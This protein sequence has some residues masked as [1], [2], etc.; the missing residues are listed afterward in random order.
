M[1]GS[2][3]ASASPDAN[4]P[5]TEESLLRGVQ[6]L[7]DRDQDLAQISARL[8]PPPLWPREPGFAT[9]I[10]IILEQQVSLASARAAFQ[11]LLA[12]ANPLT[13][14]TFL[15]LDDDALK[16]AGFSRQKTRYGRL[17]AQ[18]VLD[19]ALDI[20]GLAELDDAA[21]HAQLTAIKGIGPWTANIY[22]L[23]ALRRPD[24]WPSADL[25]LMVAVQR[26][27]GLAARP[28]VQEMEAL[29]Q[30]WRPWRAVAARLLWH[31]YLN[32]DA[33]I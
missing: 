2:P 29:G 30:V 7:I 13:P 20:D 4:S 5:L 23:M 19:G 6:A 31:H 25:A 12:V 10:Q 16:A 22:L 32:G 8:G 28:D 17:L 3:L 33:P 27:K 1:T 18:A 26:V 9:L 24:I 14:V 11:R 15:H 21:V